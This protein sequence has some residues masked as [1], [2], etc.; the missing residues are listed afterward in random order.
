MIFFF[1]DTTCD[2][3]IL[4]SFAL[5]VYVL[6]HIRMNS[7]RKKISVIHPLLS[8]TY[9]CLPQRKF[10]TVLLNEHS[11]VIRW[12]FITDSHSPHSQ[13]PNRGFGNL[14]RHSDCYSHWGMLLL[15]NQEC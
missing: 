7:L 8:S 11:Q 2:Q 10:L 15:G 6:T 4:L 14:W 12:G 9:N 1:L 5:H 3:V 13:S